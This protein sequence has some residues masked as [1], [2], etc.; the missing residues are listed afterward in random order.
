MGL[1]LLIC[2]ALAGCGKPSA[3]SQA[4]VSACKP[5]TFEGTAFLDCKADPTRDRIRLVLND[6]SGRGLRSL[7]RLK[8]VMGP[9]VHRVRFAMNAGMF[10]DAGGPI[11]LLVVDGKQLHAINRHA[12]SGNFHLLPNG[13]FAVADGK[14]RI[15]ATPDFAQA[16]DIGFATQSGPMLVIGGKLHPALAADGA[17]KY[18]RNAVGIDAQGVAHFV[19]SDQ[20]VSF[21][22]LARLYRDKLHCADALYLDG[23]VSS[24]WDPARGRLDHGKALGPLV[25]VE[26]IR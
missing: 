24:L 10:D 9:A 25:V 2:V 14:A 8:S 17:S 22:K 19:I 12:G 26:R 18:I 6:G 20:P 5:I 23:Y 13:V 3:P 1:L 11:G 15:V 4:T 7:D 16:S 21:G